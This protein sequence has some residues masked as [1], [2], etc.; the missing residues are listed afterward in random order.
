[1]KSPLLA[2]FLVL[3]A[4][5]AAPA[6]YPCGPA[7]CRPYWS[8]P[9]PTLADACHHT[10]GVPFSTCDCPRAYT[11]PH[12]VGYGGRGCYYGFQ[13]PSFLACPC[14][15]GPKCWAPAYANGAAGLPSHCDGNCD[16]AGGDA[17]YEQYV[18]PGA[19]YAAAFAEW[20]HLGQIP[21]DLAA[22]GGGVGAAASA[23]G[24][25]NSALPGLG[26]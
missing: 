7:N 15:R 13:E 20:E 4:T 10:T 25:I 26:F 23:G 18:G 12:I 2:V 6:V 17:G 8:A 21:N 3:V 9:S 5:T 16:S 19:G 1:M 24:A 14:D 11:S 22:A